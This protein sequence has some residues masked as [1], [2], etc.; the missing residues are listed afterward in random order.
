MRMFVSLERP[1]SLQVDYLTAVVRASTN[2]QAYMEVTE[3][4]AKRVAEN[5]P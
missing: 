2:F 3:Q 1:H 5:L 4:S